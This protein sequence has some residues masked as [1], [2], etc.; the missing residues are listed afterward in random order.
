TKVAELCDGKVT[1]FTITPEQFGMKRAL[2]SDIRGGGA[3]ENAE[4][5]RQ[6]LSG[7]AGPRRDIVLLNAA[8]GLFV[9]GKAA[10]LSEGV[11]MSAEAIDS[12]RAKEKLDMLVRL[13]NE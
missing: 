10:S 4:I 3:G 1:M 6:V 13:T 9:G 11:S 8:A 2:L 12:G 5:I 7:T